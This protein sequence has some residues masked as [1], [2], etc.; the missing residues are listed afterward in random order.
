MWLSYQAW[1]DDL[2]IRE[3]LGQSAELI[4]QFM[5]EIRKQKGANKSSLRTLL[6]LTTQENYFPQWRPLV[7]QRLQEEGEVAR[8]AAIAAVEG[9]NGRI[10]DLGQVT[11]IRAYVD[12]AWALHMLDAFHTDQLTVKRFRQRLEAFLDAYVEGVKPYYDNA[13]WTTGYNKGVLAMDVAS[14]VSLLYRGSPKYPRMKEA[15]STFWHNVTTLSYDGDNSPHYDA[16]TGFHAILSMA[17]R[18]GK[19]NEVIGSVHLRRMMDRMA[20]TVMSSGQSAKWGKS[21]EKSRGA[22][23]RVSAGRGLPWV[24]KMGYLLW[25]EPFYLYVARKYERFYMKKQGPF[26]S[27]GYIPDLWPLNIDAPSVS[28]ARPGPDDFSSR[29]TPRITSSR[30]YNGLLLGRG[31]T[32]YI[33]VQ[34]KL[35]LSTGHHPRAPYLLMDLSYTQHK[36]ARDHRSGLDIQN[37]NGAHTITRKRRWAEANKNNGIYLNPSAYDYPS[38]PY[39]SSEVSAPGKKLTFLNTVGYNPAFDYTIDH[40]SAGSVSLEAAYGVVEYSRYQYENVSAKR[41]VVLLH[42]G[43]VVVSDTISAS[44]VY[45]GGHKGGSLYQVLPEHKSEVGHNWVL[46]KGIPKQLPFDLPEGE[47]STLDTLVLFASV[48]SEATIALSKNPYDPVSREW[49][50]THTPVLAG[51]E[52]NLIS[53]IIPLANSDEKDALL[54]GIE[55]LKGSDSRK[56]RIPYTGQQQLEVEF[57]KENKAEFRFIDL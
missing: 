50:H 51:E 21:M 16:N 29:A 5:E 19:E 52:Y 41:E 17:V 9:N 14:T 23:L 7:I 10:N 42:N 31:D 34:D 22:Y 46:L 39:P 8:Q 15:F 18:Q 38:A 32:D 4:E 49:F 55:V 37:F 25:G 56:V 3:G 12:Y 40:Y 30:A 44:D 2:R 27:S 26:R 24:L 57:F 48:P 53:L 47:K 35:V 20:R 45:T 43:I 1:L 28:L 13:F 33:N 54:R 36:A 6:I 11:P